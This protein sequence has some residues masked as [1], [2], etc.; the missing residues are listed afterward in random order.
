MHLDIEGKAASGKVGYFFAAII[1]R[2]YQPFLYQFRHP[3]PVLR[4]Q[5]TSLPGA[6]GPAVFNFACSAVVGRATQIITTASV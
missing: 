6:S 2:P 5:V 3:P 4:A 1:F